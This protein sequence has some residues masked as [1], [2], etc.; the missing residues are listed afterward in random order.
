LKSSSGMQEISSSEK[1]D[2]TLVLNT[3]K[4]KEFGWLV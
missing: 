1:S 4:S 2:M 3:I